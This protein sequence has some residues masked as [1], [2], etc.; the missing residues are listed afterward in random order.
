MSPLQKIVL[1]SALPPQALRSIMRIVLGY[2]TFAGLWILLSDRAIGFL[3]HDPASILAANTLKGL[4]FVAIT[5]V[6]LLVSLL[7]F[8]ARQAAAGNMA[9]KPVAEEAG[10]RSGRG[11]LYAGIILLATVFILIGVGGIRYSLD[12]YRDVASKQLQSIARLKVSQLRGWLDERLSDSNLA[13]GSVIFSELFSS[14]RNDGNPDSYRMLLQR[15]AEFRA[16]YNYREVLVSDA[17][18]NILLHAGDQHHGMTQVLLNAVQRALTS[19]QTVMTDLFP[20]RV[21]RPQHVHLDFVAPIK[22]ANGKPAAAIALR[23]NVEESIYASLLTWPLPSA[24]A[25]IVLLRLDGNEIL[26]LNQLRHHAGPALELRVPLSDGE[27]LSARAMD[28]GYRPG[29]LVE[30]LDYR[31]IPVLGVALPVPGT[32]WRLLAK[33]DRSEALGSSHRDALWIIFAS[34]LTWVASA[35]LAALLLQRRELQYTEQERRA[36]SERLNALKLLSE[37]ADASADAI[38]AKDREGRYTLFNRAAAEL[39][40]RPID[41]VI[42]QD[43][44]YLFSP[45]HAAQMR[46]RD[47]KVLGENRHIVFEEVIDTPK[48]TYRLLTIKGPLHDESGKSVGIYGIAR[49]ITRRKENEETLRRNNEELQRFNQSMIGRELEMIRLKREVNDLAAALGQPQPYDLSAFD[50]ASPVPDAPEGQQP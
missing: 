2:A 8:V 25:E 40:G 20:M 33:M 42:G 27:L 24:S 46:A 17:Q 21:P 39:T 22:S 47:Q 44:S 36:Q 16:A 35:S 10:R 13:G 37:I 28:P 43:D 38:F 6:L 3:L 29:E 19:G 32:N 14:W 18:G 12:N 45:E 31:G 7:H 5:S 34:L 30:G 11:A 1:R 26:H 49:D 41:E 50:D 4:L 9:E 23:T 48:G 15:I